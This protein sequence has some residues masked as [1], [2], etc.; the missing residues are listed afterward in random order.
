MVKTSAEGRSIQPSPQLISVDPTTLERIM[1]VGK[2]KL[3]L[4]HVIVQKMDDDI[5]EDVQSIL[6]FGAEQLFQDEE[7]NRG[8]TCPSTLPYLL[9]KKIEPLP[10]IPRQTCN[11]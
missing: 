4:D 7:T 8:I 3:A 11:L 2:K 5:G 6:T 9:L 1:Q 10:Q